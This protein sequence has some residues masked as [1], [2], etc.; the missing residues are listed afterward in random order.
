MNRT[1]AVEVSIHAV[2]PLLTSANAG[3]E[4][5]LKKIISKIFFKNNEKFIFLYE[6][7]SNPFNSIELK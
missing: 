2:S 3:K 7:M 4:K 6:Y 1:R 5:K